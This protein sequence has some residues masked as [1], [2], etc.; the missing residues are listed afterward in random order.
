LTFEVR[1][2]LYGSGT[3]SG[4]YSSWL[5]VAGGVECEFAD[6]LSGVAVEDSAVEVVD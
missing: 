1:L 4:F 5:L 6:A 3:V 2:L